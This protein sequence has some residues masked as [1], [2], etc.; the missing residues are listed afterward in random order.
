MP[1]KKVKKKTKKQIKKRTKK[2]K[3]PLFAS[4]DLKKLQIR[5]QKRVDREYLKQGTRIRRRRRGHRVQRGGGCHLSSSGSFGN[6]IGQ[7][8]CFIENGIGA[9]VDGIKATISIVELPGDLAHD[10]S[11]PNE[12]LPANTP[13]HHAIDLL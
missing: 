4:E 11:R 2:R 9:A 1:E 3:H 13:I 10:L 6:M 12:P 5:V 7:L 8:F